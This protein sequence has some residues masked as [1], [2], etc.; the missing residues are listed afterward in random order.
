MSKG[1]NTLIGISECQSVKYKSPLRRTN[2]QVIPYAT[3]QT[4]LTKQTLPRKRRARLTLAAT[5]GACYERWICVMND[6]V[7]AE[8]LL[9]AEYENKL[10]ILQ[11]NSEGTANTIDSVAASEISG[12]TPDI[13]KIFYKYEY[14]FHGV[15]LFKR[16][17]IKFEIDESV[18]PVVHRNRPIALAYRERVE[19]HIKE[20]IDNDI[21]EGQGSLDSTEPLEWVSN[22]V[23]TGK[24][25]RD[26]SNIRLNVDV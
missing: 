4:L 24:K 17:E 9:G 2:V 13:Q 12:P 14:M 20:L 18:T 21:I 25:W 10:G 5:G 8:A 1:R 16:E 22:G 7:E 15:G 6:E 19:K 23:I 11:I 3:K 26:G